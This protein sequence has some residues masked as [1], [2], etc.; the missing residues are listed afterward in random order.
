MAST[1]EPVRAGDRNLRVLRFAAT[2]ALVAALLFIL[3]WIGTFIPLSSPTHAYIGLFT[4]AAV[5][6][7]RALAE[8]TCWSLGFGAILGAL[9]ALVYNGLG[10]F[11][12]S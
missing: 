1:P 10:G 5:S 12:R 11:F 9:I 7:G 8:G 4:P 2:G 3:C 6:P